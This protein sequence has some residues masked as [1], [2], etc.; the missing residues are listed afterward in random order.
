[1]TK[2]VCGVAATL[3]ML[4]DAARGALIAEDGFDYPAGV[5]T[6]EG[7]QG[8]ATGSVWGGSADA[9]S[10]G[11]TYPNLINAGANKFADSGTHFRSI[12]TTAG[13]PAD[14][15]GV[16]NPSNNIGKDDTTVW[17]SFIGSRAPGSWGGVS[18]FAGGE[19]HFIGNN[20]GGD[21][22]WLI[23]PYNGGATQSSTIPVSTE[24]FILLRFD[25][26]STTDTTRMWISPNLLAGEPALGT[27]DVT[28]TT[29]AGQNLEFYRIRFGTGGPIL[30]VD[31]LRLGTTFQDVA[32]IPESSTL[33]LATIGLLGLLA[34]G[35]RRRR[36]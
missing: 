34:C 11:L 22:P 30:T 33:A 19:E 15:A 6:T 10:P 16:L 14:L 7:G 4:G 20:T 35:Q 28:V 27:Q 2:T 26:T 12:D 17:M 18:P 24:S 31:E 13:S 36:R 25:F 32:P 29:G 5:I 9:T 8:W 3:C 23:I 1:M 21:N